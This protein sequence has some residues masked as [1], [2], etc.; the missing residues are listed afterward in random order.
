M[1]TRLLL[2]FSIFTTIL[3]AQ[4]LYNL[5]I[6]FDFEN[7]NIRV[8]AKVDSSEKLIELN[9]SGFKIEKKKNTGDSL[10][11][12]YTKNIKNL[13]KEYI[14]LLNNWYPM[15]KNRCSYNIKTNLNSDYKSV[16]EYTSLKID[17]LN[18]IAS[19]D[20]EVHNRLYNSINIQTYFLKKDKKLSEKFLDKSIEYI[21]L[22]E[23]MI[24]VFPYKN[25]KIVENIYQT[26]YS[27]PTF[28]LI[29]SRLL[30]KPYILNQSLGHEILH[31]YFGNSIFNDFTKGN[32]IEGVSTYLADDY[33]KRVENL[34]TLQRKIVLNEYQ[35]FVNA[36]DEF[37][38]KDFI[39][40]KDKVSSL[41]GY[42]KLSFVFH[43]LEKKIGKEKFFELIKKFYSENRSK[44]VNIKELEN[45]FDKNTAIDLK[46]FFVQWFYKKG[47]IDFN[48]ENLNT[49]YDKDGFNL[50]FK[51]S[52]KTK[53]HYTFDLP[54]KIKTY[55]ETIYKTLNITKPNE[56]FKL[57]FDS[58]VLDIVFDENIDIFRKLTQKEKPLSI[59]SLLVEKDLIA[60]VNKEQKDK[61]AIIKRVFP[62]AKILFSDEIKFKDI[63]KNSV[64]FLDFNNRVLNSF[65]P[66]VKVDKS[67]SYIDVKSHIYNK[68]KKMAVINLGEYKNRYFMFLKH[69]SSYKELIFTEDEVIKKRD[70]TFNGIEFV[71]NNL[72]TIEKISKRQNL[73]EIYEQIK[74]KRVIYVGET[75]D[76]FRHHLNQ[77]RVIK[78]LHKNGKK[79]A[80]AMEMFQ[81]PFQKYLD[82][83]IDG[84]LTLDQF[85]IK[86]QYFK[87]WK[88]DYN[89]YKPIL[90]YA[91]KN[92]IR[93]IA[94]NIRRDITKKVSK[95]GLFSLSKEEKRLLPKSIDQSNLEYKKSLED[96]FKDHATSSK[97]NI[98]PMPKID[99][100]LFYQSQ[101]IWDEI[102]AQ[103]I[104]EYLQKNQDTI[105]V[106][107]AG[108]G[109]IEN[110]SGIPSRV[111]RRN[112]LP[113]E[114]I[115]NDT[116]R[117]MQG[118]ILIVNKDKTSLL[119]QKRLGVYLKSDTNLV[120]IDIIKDS[121]AKKLKMKK[122][123]KLIQ[124]QSI[125]VQTIEDV[126]RALYLVNKLEN[127]NVKVLRGKKEIVLRLK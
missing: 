13:N 63:K 110:H 34:D 66:E 24:G 56:K 125:D 72:P 82:E 88:F 77:L 20:F 124:I 81:R 46:E 117:V 41:I 109:H 79:I 30:N 91:K 52:Q 61:Y 119:T 71:L 1:L 118:D 36:K 39:Y 42:S 93:V 78:S 59:A 94:L 12:S 11:F 75:H 108:A 103:T 70:K 104:D 18:F 90:D 127:I 29:G 76:N 65:F 126:K 60:V 107:I 113:F 3:S 80:I 123:D 17:R 89:L 97:S 31:Q 84:K 21:K 105:V 33:Y 53:N 114:V 7:K 35:T 14:Y 9:F 74:D 19:K 96:I 95:K 99:T 45:F 102:M 115:L 106:V 87:R 64:L 101:L 54:I 98:H 100:D 122:N 92:K 8:D 68:S 73:K 121:L 111:Y 47:M 16:Y 57:T 43:M 28:T 10:S 25:F 4:C 40:K 62:K 5:D 116:N 15:S 112:S 26:G 32:W 6:N 44:E 55:D 37:A 22:Y 120:V 83:Y 2:I 51:I 27:M 69:Y 67:S 86:T 58:E 38:V 85:L 49:Y 23:K 50:E 48:V